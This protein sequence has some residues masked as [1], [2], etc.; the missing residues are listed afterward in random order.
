MGKGAKLETKSTGSFG[1]GVSMPIAAGN[2]F[3]GSFEVGNALKDAM[4]LP[5]SVSLSTS[6]LHGFQDIISSNRELIILP[7][8]WDRME[9]KTFS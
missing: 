8:L 9:R 3:I 2:L 6:I 7:I 4:R 1:A 5:N